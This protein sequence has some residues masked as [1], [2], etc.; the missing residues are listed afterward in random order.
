MFDNFKKQMD[1]FKNWRYKEMKT[2]NEPKLNFYGNCKEKSLFSILQDHC[3]SLSGESCIKTI[4]LV[5][6]DG[7]SHHREN[8]VDALIIYNNRKCARELLEQLCPK[9]WKVDVFCCVEAMTVEKETPSFGK[10][11]EYKIDVPMI[12]IRT[13]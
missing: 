13:R 5:L 7:T 11:G 9:H 2:I 4:H 12:A 3:I 10:F 1:Q 6:S 8:V